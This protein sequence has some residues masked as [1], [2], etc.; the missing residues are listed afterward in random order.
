[1]ENAAENCRLNGVEGKILLLTGS[2]EL[3]EGQQ[4]DTVLSNLTCEV[5]VSLLASYKRVLRPSGIVVCAGVLTE[6]LPILEQAARDH[7]FSVRR[8]EPE[9]TWCG[10]ILGLA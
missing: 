6:K 4:F 8:T 2:M 5:I 1:M 9:G 7:G 3:V 10:V